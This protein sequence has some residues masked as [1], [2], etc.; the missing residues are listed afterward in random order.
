MSETN[1]TTLKP[2]EST[3]L[4]LNLLANQDKL[5]GE[6]Q[7]QI[8]NLGTIPESS[9][10][11]VDLSDSSSRKSSKS[12]SR[13]NSSSS[14]RSS[15]SNRSNRSNRSSK[16]VE[17][18]KNNYQPKVSSFLSEKELKM[19]KIDLLKKLSDLKAKGFELTKRYDLSSSVD[20]MEEEY[21]LIKKHMDKTNG[22]KLYRNMLLTGVSLIEFGNEK[23]DPI[24]FHLEGW[25][26]HTQCE[27]ESYDEVLD[28]LYEKYGSATKNIP[29]E[30]RII[31]MLGMS[32]FTYNMAQ[33]SVGSKKKPNITS[34]FTQGL[35][36]Q[37]K[38]QSRFQS[39]EEIRLQQLR[40]QDK[41][42]ERNTNFQP[43]GTSL[44]P[45]VPQGLTPR[46]T[47]NPQAS[48]ILDKMKLNT[49]SRIISETTLDSSDINLPEK[50]GR[51]P[52]SV[53][54]IDT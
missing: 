38:P 10:S 11:K 2:T 7:Y 29:P 18:I 1:D 53:I 8:N 20:E 27:I 16:S 22:L 43:A 34:N 37:T 32:A 49:Q 17:S 35:F 30:V 21:E 46:I 50:F 13:S 28:E 41:Q 15:V 39:Q 26:E 6:A 3:D 25:A 54:K 51:K 40:E 4:Y 5:V 47:I 12:R 44:P 14:S 33:S 36:N 31:F 52:K 23:Y 45:P 19:K 42:R 9:T 24:G 48:S